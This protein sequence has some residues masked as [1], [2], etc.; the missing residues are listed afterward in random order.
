MM[1][2]REIMRV[3]DGPNVKVAEATKVFLELRLEQEAR[4]R[5]KAKKKAQN[6]RKSAGKGR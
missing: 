5:E 2:V 6:R 1:K 3:P 4:D